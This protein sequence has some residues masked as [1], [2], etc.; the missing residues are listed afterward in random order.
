M[1]ID[2]NAVGE[3]SMVRV[4]GHDLL[5]YMGQLE[6]SLNKDMFEQRPEV[7]EDT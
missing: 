6:T 5:F 1:S 7:S 2:D 4:T 3:K